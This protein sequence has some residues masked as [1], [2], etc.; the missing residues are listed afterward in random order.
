M[1]SRYLFRRVRIS[2]LENPLASIRKLAR[3]SSPDEEKN[4]GR[5]SRY[6]SSAEVSSSYSHLRKRNW[7]KVERFP[8]EI[9]FQTIRPEVF[10]GIELDPNDHLW[11]PLKPRRCKAS[12][13]LTCSLIRDRFIFYSFK[14]GKFDSWCRLST[15]HPNSGL[16]VGGDGD[17]NIFQ[18]IN[19][20]MN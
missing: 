7:N 13:S 17:L 14:P 4:S 3:N 15:P 19:L 18:I 9:T 20:K 1:S 11:N 16:K 6:L 2:V 10:F 12:E 8:D 5:S